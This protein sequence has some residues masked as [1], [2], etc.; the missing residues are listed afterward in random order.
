MELSREVEHLLENYDDY[1]SP[2][3]ASDDLNGTEDASMKD[4]NEEPP[5]TDPAPSELDAADGDPEGKAHP[6]CSGAGRR[7]AWMCQRVKRRSFA[8]GH[9][10]SGD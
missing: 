10:H 4:V 9:Q 1:A 3:N 6:S 5:K 8:N 2:G 7:P